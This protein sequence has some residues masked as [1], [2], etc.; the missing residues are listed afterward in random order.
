MLREKI[1]RNSTSIFYIVI[2]IIIIIIINCETV[3]VVIGALGLVKKGLGKC[4]GKIPSNFNIEDLQ[5][6]CLLGTAHIV[7]KVLCTK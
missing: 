6:I 7:R 5:K 2:I 3:R 4:A 1:T